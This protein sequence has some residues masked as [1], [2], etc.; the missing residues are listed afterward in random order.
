MRDVFLE[1]REDQKQLKHSVA[2]LR[3]RLV[4]SFFEVFDDRERIRKQPLEAA[5]IHRFPAA[6]VL[7]SAIRSNERFVEKVV[8][9]ELFGNKSHWDRAWTPKP[10]ARSG[11]GGIHRLLHGL[12]ADFLP[13]HRKA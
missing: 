2:L 4:R 6:E 1:I 3:I 5:R 11:H 8:E 12:G 9:A 7:Q 13:R 10:A